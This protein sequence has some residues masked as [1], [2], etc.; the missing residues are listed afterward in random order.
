MN[1]TAIGNVAT[2]SG[3]IGNLASGDVTTIGGGGSNTAS[4]HYSTVGGGSYNKAH[5]WYSVVSGG[6]CD[7]RFP[8]DSNSVIGNYSVVPGGQAN[9]VTGNFSL[10]A[11][12]KAKA[13]HNG[14]FV[15]ADT[16]YT[17]F[18]S[19]ADN[20]FLIRAGGNV[21]I[22]TN[23]PASPLTVAG[24]IQTTS[25]GYKFPDGTIQTTA[26]SG[27]ISDADSII[28]NEITDAAN[29][30]LNRSGSGTSGSPYKLSLNLSNTNTWSG[31]QS[32]IAN[33]NF[34]SG[35]WNTSGNVGIG[36]TSPGLK[37]EVFGTAGVTN[38]SVPTRKLYMDYSSGTAKINL[39]T[40]SDNIAL[41][42]LGSDKLVVNGATGN[43]GIRTTGPASPLE[44]N[45]II[46][47]TAGGVKF[48]DNTVQTT[49]YTGAEFKE[50]AKQNSELRAE[51][52]QLKKAIEDIKS[53]NNNI[54]K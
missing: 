44:V 39:N 12:R 34:P 24:M 33:T 37:L 30:T 51:I 47:S 5:G 2:I 22:N 3:G 8:V 31:S 26:S 16:T 19:T 13:N 18:T 7:P 52:E 27:S 25:G 29:G 38:Q 48:P 41:A 50:L 42:I 23:S 49:A 43:V 10:A 36:T 45:G 9:I 35:I 53:Q 40:S 28:G 1:N 6:G 21:G 20:Q 46:H 32:F 14:T 17:D 54:T 4:G 15:W 11:G